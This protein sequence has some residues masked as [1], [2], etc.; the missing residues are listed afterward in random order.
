MKI[1][2]QEEYGLRCLLRI[3][4]VDDGHALTIPEIATAEGLSPPYVAKLLAVMRQGELIE[5]VR[6]RSG[7]Y[8]LSSPPAEIGLGTVLGVLGEPL[9]DDP[10]YCQ[11]HAGTE[12]EGNCV[13]HG[14]GCTLR[15]LWLTLEQWM[16]RTLSQI[17]L[18]DLLQTEN[19][20]TDLLRTRL[21]EAV[22]EPAESLITLTTLTK[23]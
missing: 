5:S 9:F 16:Q 15:A 2:S 12:T 14:G 13:H 19:R 10:G 21:A 22:L 7:G 18:A 11:R 8:R 3:A 4:A 6:G 20:I 17:T 23:N 1:S